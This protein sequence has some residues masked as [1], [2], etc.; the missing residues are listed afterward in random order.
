MLEGLEVALLSSP[1]RRWRPPPGCRVTAGAEGPSGSAAGRAAAAPAQ[2]CFVAGLIIVGSFWKRGE[3]WQT[4]ASNH[5][6]NR[7]A[8]TGSR[9]LV[10][11]T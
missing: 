3:K 7:M 1:G 10:L 6:N 11:T 9:S 8:S 5:G 4:G 2:P